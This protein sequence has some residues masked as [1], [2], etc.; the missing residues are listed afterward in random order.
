[1]VQLSMRRPAALA[2]ATAGVLAAGLVATSPGA[3][4]SAPAAE[5]TS[6]PVPI[7]TPDGAVSAYVL[8]AKQANPGQAKLVERAV[9]EAGGVIV[10]SW[11]QIGVVVAHA[12]TSTFRAD[13]AEAADGALASVGATRT[14][15]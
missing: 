7:A 15:P 6:T 5:P 2:L 3:V 13:V 8:N 9:T 11:P 12:T 10:Q 4:A 1:M 14:V